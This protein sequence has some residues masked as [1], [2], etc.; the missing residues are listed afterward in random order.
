MKHLTV[1]SF[2]KTHYN[3]L[4]IVNTSI[5]RNKNI[6]NIFLY[7]DPVEIV[8]SLL[9]IYRDNR[10]VHGL[11]GKKFIKAHCNNM[12]RNWDLPLTHVVENFDNLIIEKDILELEKMY[13]FFV[14]NHRFDTLMVK[15][16]SIWENKNKIEDYVN[17]VI[18][19]PEKENRDK[20]NNEHIWKLIV[21]DSEYKILNN[22]YESLIQK[23]EKS[24]NCWLIKKKT[25]VEKRISKL[26]EGTDKI[27]SHL[28]NLNTPTQ[29]KR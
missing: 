19:L 17:G 25:L 22:T 26:D 8:L 3:P 23:I 20:K 4:E 14:D 9:S 2:W 12:R 18:N 13:D 11:K 16:D 10:N 24:D 29:W 21:S 28:I 5:I 1:N 6:K 27:V 7:R 15:Y